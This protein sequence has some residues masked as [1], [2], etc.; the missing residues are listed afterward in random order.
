MFEKGFDAWGIDIADIVLDA[1]HDRLK[2]G[3]IADMSMFPSDRFDLV[4]AFDV[5]EH[6]PSDYI[7]K[8]LDEIDRVNKRFLYAILPAANPQSGPPF[9]R[10]SK[11]GIYEHYIHQPIE[12]WLS[13]FEKYGYSEIHIETPSFVRPFDLPKDKH[14]HL[15]LEK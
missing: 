6:I 14:A 9:I 4:T 2:Q 5:L 15:V 3:T 11:Q 8:A 12:Y 1:G 10:S 7:D 13:K